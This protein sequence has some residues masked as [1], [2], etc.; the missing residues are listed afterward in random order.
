MKKR[1]FFTLFVVAL[2]CAWTVSPA[3][4]HAVFVRAIPAP[5]D[6]LTQSPPQVDIYFSEDVQDG[7]SNISVYDFVGCRWMLA[8][9]AWTMLTRHV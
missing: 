9:C 5:N 2:Y 7:L 4:A 6:V 8:T 1:L 3:Q